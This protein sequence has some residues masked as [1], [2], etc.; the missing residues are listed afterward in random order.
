MVK[1][2]KEELFVQ[3]CQALLPETGCFGGIGVQDR[4]VS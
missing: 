4:L 3:L 2:K 1:L